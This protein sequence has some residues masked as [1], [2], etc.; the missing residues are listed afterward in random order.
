M[1]IFQIVLVKCPSPSL[2]LAI[3]QNF[4]HVSHIND[5]V[6]L[7]IADVDEEGLFNHSDTLTNRQRGNEVNARPANLDCEFLWSFIFLFVSAW[8]Y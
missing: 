1:L 5:F 2:A 4:M 8:L 7:E 3:F 6:S